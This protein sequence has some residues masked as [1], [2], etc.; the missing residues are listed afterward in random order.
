MEKSKQIELCSA[1]T[2]NAARIQSLGVPGPAAADCGMVELAAPTHTTIRRTRCFLT[3][4]AKQSSFEVAAEA[5]STA[6]YIPHVT[7][8]SLPNTGPLDLPMKHGNQYS[9]V[10]NTKQCSECWAKDAYWDKKPRKFIQL[11]V[12]DLRNTAERIRSFEGH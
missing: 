7:P 11:A 8:S 5:S 3:P 12:P 10:A 2:H 6:N 1:G 9:V 4:D